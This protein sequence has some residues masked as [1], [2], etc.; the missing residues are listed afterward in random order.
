MHCGQLFDNLGDPAMEQVL[1]EEQSVGRYWYLARHGGGKER[2]DAPGGME[3]TDGA[4]GHWGECC[5]PD[6]ALS[7]LIDREN[8]HQHQGNPCPQAA[9]AQLRNISTPIAIFR[10]SLQGGASALL[11]S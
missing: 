3:G 2:T 6:G 5:R 1:Q 10:Y 11:T 7:Q 8:A 4:A 9:F